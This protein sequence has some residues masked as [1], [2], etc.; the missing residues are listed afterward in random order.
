M[1]VNL[2]GTNSLTAHTGAF[3]A[4]AI[5]ENGSITLTTTDADTFLGSNASAIFAN[6]VGG[7]FIDLGGVA[8]LLGGISADG[9]GGYATTPLT[10]GAAR[11]STAAGSL[12]GI[13]V[14]NIGSSETTDI[15]IGK[16]DLTSVIGD[17][18]AGIAMIVTGGSQS[19]KV[20]ITTATDSSITVA[21]NGSNVVGALPVG[22][23]VSPT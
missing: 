1:T 5:N 8:G 23:D 10:Q 3:G 2:T 7:G 16:G 19:G 17:N 12:S 4:L 15:S 21:G 11:P 20:T 22:V 18:S 9:V 6:T 13:F 14:T